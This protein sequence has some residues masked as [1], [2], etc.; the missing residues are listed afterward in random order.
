MHWLKA[1]GELP[2]RPSLYP[3]L[4]A[5]NSLGAIYGFYWYRYQLQA[6]PWFY[7]PV[8]PDSPLAVLFFTLVLVELSRGRR[9][10][11]LEALG[12]LGMLKYGLWT[13][14]V[15]VQAGVATGNYDF[16]SFHLTLSHLGMALEAVLFLRHYP[17]PRPY[18]WGEWLWFLLNDYFDY[19]RGTHPYL[20]APQYESFA[21]VVAVAMTLLAQ[22]IVLF[23]P[24]R[25]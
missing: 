3:T 12:Y 20:P 25:K 9:N 16:E 24:R 10:H 5:V 17:P 15:L 6:T 8:V 11:G 21:A 7:W 18:A 14:L 22:A 23:L 1:L 2:R 4:I 13:P 19:G